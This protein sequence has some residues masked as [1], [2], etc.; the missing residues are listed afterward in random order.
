MYRPYDV[1]RSLSTNLL[2]RSPDT[3]FVVCWAW[4][5]KRK[6]TLCLETATTAPLSTPDTCT[7]VSARLNLACISSFIFVARFVITASDKV[8]EVITADAIET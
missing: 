6:K 8:G 4:G 7:A 2:I 1:H 5:H 3:G